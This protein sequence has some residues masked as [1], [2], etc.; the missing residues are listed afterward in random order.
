MIYLI[1]GPVGSG[2]STRLF[3]LYRTMSAMQSAISC[4]GFYNLRL[5]E[6]GKSIGQDLVHMSTGNRVPFSRVDN[7]IPEGWVEATRYRKYSFSKRGL[8]FAESIMEQMAENHA[9]KAFIDE[10]GPLELKKEGLYHGFQRLAACNIDV[11]AVCRDGCVGAMV[12]L[13]QLANPVIC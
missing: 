9:D 2:K 5:Y 7:A 10:L 3:D 8:Q 12:A 1:T 4:D 13:L 6:H 11:Y